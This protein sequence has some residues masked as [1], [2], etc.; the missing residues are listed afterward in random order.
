MVWIGDV[1]QD[2]AVLILFHRKNEKS[3]IVA[4]GRAACTHFC[5]SCL[6]GLRSPP[7]HDLTALALL[8]DRGGLAQPAAQRPCPRSRSPPALALLC[9]RG[10]GRRSSASSARSRWRSRSPWRAS[11]ARSRRLSPC[12]LSAS[13]RSSRSLSNLAGGGPEGGF[14][15]LAF[16]PGLAFDTAF[17]SIVACVGGGGGG[18]GQVVAGGGGAA[19]SS[20]KSTEFSS[21]SSS[22]CCVVAADDRSS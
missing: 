2:D 17:E 11:R 18:F 16:E 12:R 4:T 21:S 19:S 20:P 9:D 10:S 6:A 22:S 7:D 1:C 15:C 13:S 8:C 3:R 5:R 14:A